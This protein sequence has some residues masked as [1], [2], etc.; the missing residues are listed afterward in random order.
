VAARTVGCGAGAV[1]RCLGRVWLGLVVLLVAGALSG[2]S[3]ALGA[4]SGVSADVSGVDA[5]LG[6]G[7]AAAAPLYVPLV[8]VRVLDTRNEVHGDL[9]APVEPRQT[10]TTT[11]GGVGGVPAD[12]LAVAINI[13]AVTPTRDGYVTVWP[14]GQPRPS[15]SSINFPA[16]GIVGNFVLA[17]L[18]AGGRLAIYNHNGQTDIVFD[19]V[20]YLPAGSDYTPVAPV[21]V[22]DTRDEVHGD[23]SAP[24]EPRQ[25][26]TTTVGGVGGVPA[27]ALAVAINIT[28][29]TPTR[30]GYVT[31]WPDGQ[32]RPTISSINFPAG[33]IV[34]NFVLAEL[35]AGGRLAIYNHNGQTDIVF[36]VVGYL[37]A[38]ANPTQLTAGYAH[39]CARRAN[40]TVYCWGN[41]GYGQLG[42]G[43]PGGSVNVLPVPVVGMTDS[44]ELTAGHH[45]TCVRHPDATVS[46]WGWNRHG[47]L[48]DG[49][50]TDRYLPT[51]VFGLDDAAQ[52]TAAAEHT[53][54][55]HAG[56]DAS[57]WG[58]NDFGQLGDDTQIDRPT[59]T[60]VAG[61]DYS[62]VELTAGSGHTCGRAVNGAASCWGYNGVGQLGD[63]TFTVI[64][65][66]PYLSV[67]GLHDAVEVAAGAYHTCARHA[68]ATVSCWGYNNYGQLGNGTTTTSYVPTLVVGID[69]AVELT[70][71]LTHT[72]ARHANG[73]V[74]CWGANHIGQLGDGTWTRSL[75]PTQAVGI[76]DAVQLAAGEYHTC[77]LHADT[78]VSCWG[79]NASGQLGVGGG[80]RGTPT[81]VIGLP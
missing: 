48:G 20:G 21:R 79:A 14:D 1:R 76:N 36:D 74:S 68:D 61:G 44:V 11:V 56:W 16:G 41:D 64:R 51:P 58:D 62:A 71:G 38:A 23:L 30:D 17:E 22:L 78:T 77:A 6:S 67:L 60:L 81:K 10:V 15:I 12:A 27:D 34:G 46:C 53:C 55:R 65:P 32:P 42:Q 52:L 18:G 26:V 50:T 43:T 45:H 40:G 5:E 75:V 37:P 2:V 29:V 66:A 8:P 59:P 13:T 35:G 49:T 80:N 63:G 69:D 25:T 4:G 3:P 47:Q 73:S 70:A 54:V 28:A 39:T 7:L 31:V 33:G 57:C 19:V 72:C 9:S 24:V